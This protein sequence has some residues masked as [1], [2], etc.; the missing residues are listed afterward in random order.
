M[1]RPCL[2][3][4][5]HT[6]RP[7]YLAPAGACDCHAHVF[8]PSSQFPYV[9]ERSFTPPDALVETY[10]HMLDTIGVSRAIL[11]QG[12]V[13]GTDNTL[14][15]RSVTTYSDR[16]RGVAVIGP[17]TPDFEI[18]NLHKLGFR[19]TRLSTVVKGTP[20]FEHLQTIASKV[21]SLGWHIVV[22]VNR[23]EELTALRPQLE[24][25]GCPLLIDH[26]A[27]VRREEGVSS[28]GFQTLLELLDRGNCWVKV[29][30]QHR[31]SAQS[32]PWADML[33]LV[34]GVVEARPDR[35][36]WGSDWPHPNQF[37]D[38]QNDGD[39]LD[40]FAQWVPEPN[41]RQQ[42]LVDNPAELYEFN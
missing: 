11:V 19:G 27:R 10:L 16:L 37:E 4:D 23:S 9:E 12:S 20:G 14:V 38:M 8:G 25:T 31:M 7:Y 2:P 1:T 22:H 18:H 26:I 15:A 28:S 39:L 30:G 17:N 35:V 40:A 33:P 5:P 3:P 29:S 34:R 21:R 24:A 32:Y 36:L 13:H 42:I 41:L 6:R